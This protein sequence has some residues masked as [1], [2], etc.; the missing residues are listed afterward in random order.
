MDFFP[1]PHLYI[2]TLSGCSQPLITNM[3]PT[4]NL[5]EAYGD[6][7]WFARQMKNVLNNCFSDFKTEEEILTVW[8]SKHKRRFE[9]VDL[10]T[11]ERIQVEN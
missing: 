1:V 9:V 5:D 3:E 11:L 8:N 2:V 10:I 4:P 7:Q 6:A